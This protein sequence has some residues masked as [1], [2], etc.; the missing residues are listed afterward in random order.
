MVVDGE[1]RAVGT[2]NLDIRSLE[3]HKELM[4]WIYDE[5]LAR[6]TK[7][8]FY[9]DLKECR[10]VTLEEVNAFGAGARFRNSAARLASK[11]I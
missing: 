3:L 4:V 5:E 9:D 7:Q 2:M 11:L 6:G 10:E 8:I 1:G